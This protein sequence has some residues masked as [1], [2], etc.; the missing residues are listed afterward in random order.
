MIITNCKNCNK[1]IEKRKIDKKRYKNSFCSSKCSY[2]YRTNNTTTKKQC[3]NCGIVFSSRLK[4]N[5][6]F[7]SSS[8]AAIFNNKNKSTGGRRSKLELYIE[9]KLTSIFPELE[10]LFNTKEVIGSELDIYIPS[11]NIAFELNGIFHYEPIFGSKKF[12]QI[13]S[14]DANKTIACYEH[15]IDLCVIDTTS[16]KYFKKSSSD[17]FLEIIIKIIDERITS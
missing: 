9:E 7:C 12:E 11:L 5:R 15:G 8:C 2:E 13:K 10:I 3:I 17:K 1:E 4:E 16:Q 6:K 14:N